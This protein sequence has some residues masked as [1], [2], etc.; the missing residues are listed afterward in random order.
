[1]KRTFL[2]ISFLLLSAAWAVAQYGSYDNQGADSSHG[3]GKVT[4]VGCLDQAGG[5]FTLTDRWG[6]AYQLIGN[7]EKLSAHV[8]QTI[9]VT[10][11]SSLAGQV[12]GSMSEDTGRQPSLSVSSFRHVSSKCG[13]TSREPGGSY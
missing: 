3:S 9:Q 6:T 12:P 13:V 4:V 2:L 8:G 10:G 7:T 11:N 5:T 1:M